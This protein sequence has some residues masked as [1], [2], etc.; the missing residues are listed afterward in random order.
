MRALTVQPGGAGSA[1][2][3]EVAEPEPREGSLVVRTLAMGV[4][5]TDLEIVAGHHGRAAGGRARLILGHESL[6]E[7][8]EAP[9]GSGFAVGE[10]VVGIVRRP[11]PLPCPSCAAGEWDMCTNG[12]YTERGIAGH[13]GYGSERF[14]VEP[15]FAVRVDPWL[16]LEAVLLEPASVLA[17]AWEHVERIGRRGAAWRPRT[18]LVT[19]AGPVGLLATLLGVQRGLEMHVFDRVDEGPKPALVRDFG[20]HYHTG[21]LAELELAPDAVIECTGAAPVILDG[22]SR[23]APGGVVCL[24]SLSAYAGATPV[25]LASLNR[26]IVMQNDVV[27]GSVNANRRHYEAA[28]GALA[29]ADRAWLARLVTRCVPLERWEEA[30]RQDPADVKVVLDFT[31]A[32]SARSDTGVAG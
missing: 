9:P 11:D 2:L 24:T 32:A 13:D 7:V 16:G 19:G 17:K 21:S 6:G 28:A 31:S 26:S 25:A 15:A 12:L 22:M 1:R 10:R 4:C 3:E 8:V 29:R 20:A 23:T 18:A 14:R 27:F 5:G 30:L